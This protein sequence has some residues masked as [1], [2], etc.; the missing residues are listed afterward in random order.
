ML[1]ISLKN[2]KLSS[3]IGLLGIICVLAVFIQNLFFADATIYRQIIFYWITFIIAVV[4]MIIRRQ[5]YTTELLLTIFAIFITITSVFNQQIPLTQ[6]I[7]SFGYMTWWIWT[8]I[9][10]N[11]I[12]CNT[13]TN[14]KGYINF[15]TIFTIVVAIYLLFT[16]DI[17]NQL[18]NSGYV[19]NAYYCLCALPLIS[20]V[21]APKI[22]Y[23]SIAVC[24]VAVFFSLKRSGIV[25]IGLMLFFCVIHKIRCD[26]RVDFKV[27][28]LIVISLLVVTQ[29]DIV[30]EV[31]NVDFLRRFDD[32]IETGGNGRIEIYQRTW[33]NISSG[34]FLRLLVGA[35][36]N[37]N[38]KFYGETYSAHND[39]LE[40]IIDYGIVGFAIYF[41]L[42]LD[43]VKKC[44]YHIKHCTEYA[45]PC[46]MALCIFGV[47][48]LLSHLVI[49][50]SY[51]ILLII[52]FTYINNRPLQKSL[53]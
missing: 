1:K 10:F 34:G 9:I 29:Y 26:K 36:Y 49:Y 32:T 23:F 45:I 3:I 51:F 18:Q 4:M 30:T 22:R 14:G 16:Y 17:Q 33:N 5:I 46:I 7:I 52:F 15:F 2:V 39:F 37:A 41:K 35:G 19:N 53:R 47:L 6:F 43:I 27:V 11:Y 50:P 48:S 24:V 13:E 31:F 20:L 28:L 12:W 25:A 44:R 40:I 38:I 42:I 8:Y 21:T